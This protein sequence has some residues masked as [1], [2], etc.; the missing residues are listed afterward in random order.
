MRASAE[1][2]IAA[3]PGRVW[4]VMTDPSREGRWMRAVRRAEFVGQAGYEPGARMRR[5]GRFLGKRMEWESEIAECEP[6]RRIVFRH[7]AGSLRGESRWE[8]MRSAGGCTVRLTTE[9][10]LPAGLGFLRPLAEMGARMALR[11][12]LRRLKNLVESGA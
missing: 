2:A 7:I 11:G 6:D 5:S 4:T 8:I 1:V 12:D 10:P 9:G 3:E